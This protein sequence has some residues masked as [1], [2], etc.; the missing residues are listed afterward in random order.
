MLSIYL[1]FP[2]SAKS[3]TLRSNYLSMPHFP[4]TIGPYK[5]NTPNPPTPTTAKAAHPIC[6]LPPSPVNGRVVVVV[7][8]VVFREEREEV[9]VLGMA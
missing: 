9:V 7:V 8:V 3:Q 5:K 2:P 4:N 1:I 6:I